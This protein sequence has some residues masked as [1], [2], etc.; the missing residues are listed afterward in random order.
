MLL[1]IHMGV[2]I[3]DPLFYFLRGLIYRDDQV[4]NKLVQNIDQ[5]DE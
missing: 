5:D 2:H 4:K 1:L 3:P